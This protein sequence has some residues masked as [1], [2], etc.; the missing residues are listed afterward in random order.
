MVRTRLITDIQ[1]TWIARLIDRKALFLQHWR[2]RRGSAG[3]PAWNHRVRVEL[4]PMLAARVEAGVAACVWRPAA[5]LA[6]LPTWRDGDSLV[7]GDGEGCHGA[8]VLRVPFIRDVHGNCVADA[9]PTISQSGGDVH[10]TAWFAC[11]LGPVAATHEAGLRAAGEFE[12]YHLFHGLSV[13]L[14]EALAEEVHRLA[15][16]ELGIPDPPGLT[17]AETVAGKYLGRRF[18]FGYPCCPDLSIQGRLL[19]LL[20]ASR[21]GISVNETF[22]MEPELSVTAGVIS[23]YAEF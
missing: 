17:P 23:G 13:A 10:R 12:E 2:F 14:A 3:Q 20:D 21:I 8:E 1:P 11:T 4:E 6:V 16:I 5:I 9:I 7:L 19:E 18:S 22:Q 15:R